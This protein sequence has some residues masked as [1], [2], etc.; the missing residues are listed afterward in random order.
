MKEKGLCNHKGVSHYK[1]F[2]KYL[3][4]ILK[5]FSIKFK[6]STTILV[7]T[8]TYFPLSYLKYNNFIGG[9]PHITT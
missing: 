7:E 6:V 1:Y 3:N 2:R 9:I 5:Q 8:S 4:F